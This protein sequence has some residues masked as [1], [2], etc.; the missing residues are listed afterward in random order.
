MAKTLKIPK[1]MISKDTCTDSPAPFLACA[2]FPDCAVFPNCAV[3]P[4][5]FILAIVRPS[6]VPASATG[7]AALFASPVYP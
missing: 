4:G 2:V 3:F 1:M 5:L 6:L 7:P